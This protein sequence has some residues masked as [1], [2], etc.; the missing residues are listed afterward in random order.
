MFTYDDPERGRRVLNMAVPFGDGV[1][2]H[3]TWDAMGMRGT[4]SNDVTVDDVFV[5][6]E[7]VLADRPARRRRPAAAG[8]LQHR[9]PDHLGRLPRR[10]RGRPATAAIEA[11]PDRADDA[12]RRS[13]RSA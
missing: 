7:R 4:A 9:L 11:R 1:T 6:D 2:V 8:H 12:D 13:A 10:R 3:D 5:P